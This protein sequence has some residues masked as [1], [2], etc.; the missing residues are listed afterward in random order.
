MQTLLHLISQYGLLFVFVNVLLVQAGAPIPA[1]PTLLLAGAFAATGEL[2][3]PRLL[4]S[5]VAASLI[6][7]FIWYLAG[8]RFGT[9]VLK[10][11]CRMS[12]SPDSCVRQTEN[13]FA[14]FGLPALLV[15]KFIPGFNTVAPPMAGAMGAP[16]SLFLLYAAGGA[17]LWAGLP[18]VLGM[19]FHD[20]ID[21][22]LELL[23][24][25]GAWTVLVLGAAV[26]LFIA[27]KWWQ[28]RRFL[29]TLR[30]AMIT[31]DELYQLIDSG[32]DPL[33]LDVRSPLAWALAPP[34]SGAVTVDLANVDAALAGLARDREIV[35]YCACPNEA[36]A[37][38]VAKMLMERGFPR[39]RPL[40]G[41][42]YPWMAAHRPPVVV[43]V[44]F[45]DEPRGEKV[46]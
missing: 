14:R 8:A 15:A 20:A 45:T 2:S 5:A 13:V 26:A 11:L 12:L 23:T 27:V 18:L 46:A 41:G 7:D 28:R 10:T 44:Q 33:I 35:V 39:V 43:A 38:R 1:L 19:V 21:R 37:A 42:Y 6:A 17:A 16:R 9:R 40:L 25:F 30:M 34:I 24:D 4:I 29:Q 3:L 31:V 36:S 22:S 32:A